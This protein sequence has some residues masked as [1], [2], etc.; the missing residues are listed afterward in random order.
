MPVF[1]VTA[2]DLYT[3]QITTEDDLVCFLSD[4]SMHSGSIIKTLVTYG[5]EIRCVHTC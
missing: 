5:T 2:G 1:S 4:G 3:I